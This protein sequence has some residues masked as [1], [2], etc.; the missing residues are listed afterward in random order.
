MSTFSFSCV[1]YSGHM[2][3]AIDTYVVQK[4]ETEHMVHR[5]I[6]SNGN[7]FK[8]YVVAQTYYASARFANSGNTNDATC[9]PGL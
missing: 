9:M 7:V 2:Y 8:I 1:S 6:K 4:L 5:T 3:W